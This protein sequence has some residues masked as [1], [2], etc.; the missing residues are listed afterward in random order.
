MLVV[1]V[2]LP[3]A[4]L[5]FHTAP[6]PPR[7][8]AAAAKL[9]DDINALNLASVECW[10][11]HRRVI[12]TTGTPADGDALASALHADPAVAAACDERKHRTVCVLA[13]RL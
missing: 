6:P 9:L 1:F 11:V 2:A 5:A 13:G 10:A 3:G 8:N 4:V 7:V 12:C